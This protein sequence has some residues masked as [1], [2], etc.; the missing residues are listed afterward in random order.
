MSR[1]IDTNTNVYISPNAGKKCSYTYNSPIVARFY[2]YDPYKGLPAV[3]PLDLKNW[4]YVY[5]SQAQ[6]G[7]LSSDVKSY[8]ESG[9]VNF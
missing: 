3:V 8:Q 6:G 5:V 9:A 1:Q 4:W 2:D 7:I